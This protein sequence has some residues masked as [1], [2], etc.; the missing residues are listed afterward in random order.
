MKKTLLAPFA[1]LFMLSVKAQKKDTTVYAG[2]RLVGDTT[3]YVGGVK[4]ELFDSCPQF[5]QQPGDYERYIKTYLKR[6][7]ISQK[8]RARVVISVI[9]ENDGNVTHAQIVNPAASKF[10]N[11]MALK[12]VYDMPKWKPAI[13]HGKPVRM[14]YL[15]PIR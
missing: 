9:I 3:Q 14:S 2:C 6:Y 15:L 10:L 5:G 1:V 12:A 7:G 13:L 8:T 11:I 4:Q